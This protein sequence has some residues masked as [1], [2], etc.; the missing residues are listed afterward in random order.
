MS[1]D[2]FEASIK[3]PDLHCVVRHWRAACGRRRMPDWNDIRP[4][5]IGQQLKIVWSYRYDGARDRLVGRLAGDH[6]E[7]VFGKTFRNT[8][9]ESLYPAEQYPAMFAR[10]RRIV[11]DPSLYLETGKVFQAVDRF[12]FG[13]RVAMPLSHDGETGDG[14]IGATVYETFLNFQ[15]QPQPDRLHWFALSPAEALS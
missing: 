6:I 2:Q 4:N 7:R 5:R 15:P 1:F 12:G 3:S 8:P 10:F 13:E 9:M 11:R 14:L